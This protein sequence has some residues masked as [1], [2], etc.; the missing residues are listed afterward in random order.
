LSKR[1]RRQG[2]KRADGHVS[3]P[4]ELCPKCNIKGKTEYLVTA[5]KT[6]NR[7]FVRVG[8][9]CPSDSCDYICK[10]SIDVEFKEDIQDEN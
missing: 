4:K 8:L 2:Q 9:V 7:K 10:D 6:K 5:W 3:T 1:S